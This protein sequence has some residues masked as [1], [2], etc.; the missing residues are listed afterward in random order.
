MGLLLAESIPVTKTT[1][2]NP[3][4]KKAL[5]WLPC[6]ASAYLGSS[7]GTSWPTVC[8]LPVTGWHCKLV[9]NLYLNVAAHNCFSSSIPEIH[10]E[11][12]WQVKSSHLIHSS[13]QATGTEFF[14][15]C[16]FSIFFLYDHI[17]IPWVGTKKV[18]LGP[19]V[20]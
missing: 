1:T 2:T 8:T 12:C 20:F 13:L 9:C 18:Y 4:N 10:F 7:A 15:Q 17:N 19:D 16:S 11:Q 14:L 5:K 6:Q 3:N